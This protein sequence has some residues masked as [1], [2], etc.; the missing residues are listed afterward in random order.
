MTPAPGSG[1]PPVTPS[2]SLTWFHAVVRFVL[3][4]A[5]LVGLG[6]WGWSLSDITLLRVFASIA[7][8]VVAAIL[9]AVFRAS[10]DT[11]AGKPAVVPVSGKI[12]LALEITLFLIAAY[13]VWTAGSRI[14]AETLLTFAG[15][16]Y[17]MT[18]QRV[19]WLLTS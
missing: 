8:P 19:R 6:Y 16:H 9:W 3:E 7:L 5:M 18:W 14:A 13:G 15:L 1:S 12:R 4:L 10:G 2:P 11:S 17:L